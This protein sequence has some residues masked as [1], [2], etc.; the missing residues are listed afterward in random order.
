VITRQLVNIAPAIV[1]DDAFNEVFDDCFNELTFD[2]T[3]GISVEGLIDRIEDL[4]LDKIEISYPADNSYCEIK[5][6]NS[7]FKIHVTPGSFTVYGPRTTSP[8]LLVESFFD[9]QKQ[10]SATPVLNAIAPLSTT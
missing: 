2:F 1:E 4:D 6:E 9:A 8:K 10:L 3:K 7:P 5:I